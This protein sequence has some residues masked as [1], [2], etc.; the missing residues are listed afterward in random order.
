MFQEK[1]GKDLAIGV[2]SRKEWRSWLRANHGTEI[3]VWLILFRKGSSKENLS[4]EEAVEEAL[5]FGWIDS[6]PN[7]RDDSSYYLFFSKRKPRSNWS[8]PNRERANRLIQSGQMHPA[9]LE[10][11]ELAKETGTWDA[12]KSVEDLVLPEDLKQAFKENGKAMKHFQSFPPSAR[13]GILEWLMNAKRSET[14]SRRIQEIVTLAE[15]NI[16]ANQY[17]PGAKKRK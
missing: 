15:K 1:K 14:R 5:C 17:N 13:K 6:K 12:L 11:I 2:S 7:K 10:M 9:G 8:K 4:Y 16:R 3:S